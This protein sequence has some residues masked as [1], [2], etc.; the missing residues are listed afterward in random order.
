MNFF[1]EG[2]PYLGHPLLTS[3]RTEAELDRVDEL[4]G[5]L[6]PGSQVVDLGCGFGRHCV[7]LA[8]RGHHVLGVDPSA[9]MVRAAEAAAADLSTEQGSV[10]FHCGVAADVANLVAP[11][12]IDLALCLFTTFGQHT[13]NAPQSAS[14]TGLL[15]AAASVLKPGG[16]L[17]LEVPEK[18]RAVSMLVADEQLG[19]T[20]VTRTYDETDDLLHERFETPQNTYNLAYQLFTTDSLQSLL[21][22]ASLAV[23][24]MVESAL[25]P[26]PPTFVTIVGTRR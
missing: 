11:E 21:E 4:I 18:A 5:G 19:P 13:D 15:A 24:T 22:D 20:K 26:P 17:V 16:F 12:S 14:T 3:E 10:R 1:D 7:A 9:T 6:A 23:E 25:V 2:S 8:A